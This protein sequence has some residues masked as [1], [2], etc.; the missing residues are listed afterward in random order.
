MSPPKP[1]RPES[2]Y[3]LLI[4]VAALLGIGLVM[5]FSASYAFAYV[6]TGNPYHFFSRQLLW[7][8]IGIIV[9]LVTVSTDYRLWREWAVPIMGLTVLALVSV[10]LVG[11]Q[12][13]G[14]Q[15]TFLGGSVQPSELA[16]VSI[17]IY[18]AAWLASKGQRLRDVSYGLVPFSILLGLIVGLIIIQPDIST[19]LLIAITAVAMFFI[20]G[21]DLKQL[22]FVIEIGRASCRERV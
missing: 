15:R 6:N 17:I 14:A 20:A 5:V 4:V 9:M 3:T 8:I 11:S 18:I 16:K 7:T 10:L 13:Y 2:D 1:T 19:S 21:A 12:R 22:G